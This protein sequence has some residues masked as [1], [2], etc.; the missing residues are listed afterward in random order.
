MLK[1]ELVSYIKDQSWFFRTRGDS[2]LLFMSSRQIGFR[3]HLRTWFGMDFADTIFLPL[4]NKP[5]RVFHAEHIDAFHAQSKKYIFDRPEILLDWIKK[6]LRTWKE[7]NDCIHELEKHVHEENN[8]ASIQDFETLMKLH[9]QSS[10]SFIIT[11]SLGLQLTKYQHEL[12]D[13]EEIIREH[14]AW[15]NKASL[16]EDMENAIRIFLQSL[17]VKRCIDCDAIRAINHLSVTEILSWIR[18]LEA[19]D[20]VARITHREKYGYIFIDVQGRDLVLIDELEE[21]EDLSNFLLRLYEKEQGIVHPDE[22]LIGRTAFGVGTLRGRVIVARDKNEFE[23]KRNLFD[24]KILVAIQTTANFIPCMKDVLAIITNEGG[25]TCHAA[26]IAREMKKPCIIGTKVA[27]K[28]L[29]DGDEIEMNC[30]TGEISI[31]KHR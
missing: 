18:D 15:R 4:Q 28:M 31:L 27:T 29:H 3:T 12:H 10:A 22:K 20:A 14:D 21:T 1:K 26:I 6:D 13:S 11:L 19:I 25:I 16:E 7:I 8:S 30:D 23:E 24:Q 17:F 9:Q 2:P 5:T